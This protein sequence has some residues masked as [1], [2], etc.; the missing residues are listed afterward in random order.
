MYFRLTHLER[1]MNTEIVQPFSQ[2]SLA[3]QNIN[4]SK[5]NIIWFDGEVC[6]VIILF[7]KDLIL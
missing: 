5:H 3:E 4:N 1:K 6:S 2:Y 7:K